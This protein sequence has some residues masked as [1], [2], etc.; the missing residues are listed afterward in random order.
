MKTI[1]CRALA[2]FAT[3]AVA[4]SAQDFHGQRADLERQ[5]VAAHAAGDVARKRQVV[6]RLE[7]LEAETAERPT[8]T[9][10]QTWLDALVVRPTEA[11]A[12]ETVELSGEGSVS[13]SSFYVE[14]GKKISIAR[15]ADGTVRVTI[16]EDMGGGLDVSIAEANGELRIGSEKLGLGVDASVK[17]GVSLGAE[18]TWT[19]D[20]DEIDLIPILIARETSQEALEGQYGH[21][22]FEW[23][24]DLIGDLVFGLDDRHSSSKDTIG[25]A[26]EFDPSLKGVIDI[27]GV[28]VAA[29]VEASLETRT[30]DDG[31]TD[32]VVGVKGEVAGG[33]A[34]LGVGAH[35]GLSGEWRITV[36]ESGDVERAEL[37]YVLRTDGLEA[38]WDAY[39]D[40]F[41]ETMDASPTFGAR[42]GSEIEIVYSLDDPED[43]VVRSIRDFS[44]EGLIP[45]PA[46]LAQLVFI[47]EVGRHGEI[48]IVERETGSFGLGL[49]GE[50]GADTQKVG[51]GGGVE[52]SRTSEREVYRWTAGRG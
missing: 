24:T 47:E 44:G 32:V 13:F 51:L 43:H 48:V 10:P 38:G 4:G 9:G 35:A 33:G 34:V 52:G 26:G 22:A 11:G 31:S 18:E 23:G 1:R 42:S 14:A 45:D 17:A 27:L 41:A 25:A 50:I 36:D 37:V 5:Y 6:A 49:A 3:L 28:D 20:E 15:D 8:E 30:G 21:W 12:S 16:G 46:T 29:G 7:A 39:A 2:L 40:L 19:F